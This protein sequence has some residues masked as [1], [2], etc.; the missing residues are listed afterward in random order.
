METLSG[1]SRIKHSI[2]A[3][4]L[5]PEVV[6]NLIICYLDRHA[7]E[8]VERIKE[9]GAA[10]IPIKTDILVTPGR[11]ESAERRA[12]VETAVRQQVGLDVCVHVYASGE[13]AIS[14]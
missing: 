3:T 13:I 14:L 7:D 9:K 10:Q 11:Y 4:T 1:I 6:A 5:S 2:A 8:I 12:L